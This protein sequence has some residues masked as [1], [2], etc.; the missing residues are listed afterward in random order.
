MTPCVA[1]DLVALD[2]HSLDDIWVD[3]AR[4]VDSTF[5]KIY[6]GDEEGGFCFVK[7]QNVEEVRGVDIWSIVI[8]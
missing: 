3:G 5:S 2:M 7:P 6:T 4:V 8:G 1:G